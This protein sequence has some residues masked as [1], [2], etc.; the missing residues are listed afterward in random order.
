M[1][2][3]KQLTRTI[4]RQERELRR[5]GLQ[6]L[7]HPEHPCG[8]YLG[9]LRPCGQIGTRCRGGVERADGI[10]PPLTMAMVRRE[11][12]E[13]RQRQR[14]AAHAGASQEPT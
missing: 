7:Y 2:E 3:Q 1:T 14:D 8:C 6:G 13:I 5:K 4:E 11:Q 10:R 12:R 9:D